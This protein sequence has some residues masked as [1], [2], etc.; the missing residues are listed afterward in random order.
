MVSVIM[1]GGEPPLFIFYLFLTTCQE[2][3]VKKITKISNK[4]VE[5]AI[6]GPPA[7]D[8]RPYNANLPAEQSAGRGII[9]EGYGLFEG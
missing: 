7:M 3:D 8:T 6:C 2:G 1:I 5:A 4:K 9:P